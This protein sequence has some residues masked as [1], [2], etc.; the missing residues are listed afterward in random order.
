[1]WR[2]K[3]D[4]RTVYEPNNTLLSATRAE[5]STA[6]SA[7]GSLEL[8]LPFGHALY[9]ELA[10]MPLLGNQW[11]TVERDGSEFWRGR[12]I[13]RN[14]KPLDGVMILLIE[15]E[16]GLL[17]DSVMPPYS[18]TESPRSYLTRLLNAHNAQVDSWKRFYTGRVRV[19]NVAGTGQITRE[20]SSP[21][22]MMQEILTKTCDSSTGGY[23]MLRRVN[24][25]RYLDWVSD[26]A[27]IGSQPIKTAYN[28]LA[29]EDVADGGEFHTAVYAT[30]AQVQDASTGDYYTLTL[31]SLTDRTDQSTAKRGALMINTDLQAKH[32]IIARVVSWQDVT[33]ADNLYTR[34][35]QYV[36]SLSEPRDIEVK[37]VDMSLTG[38]GVAPFEIG[39]RVPL[40]TPTFEGSALVTGVTYDLLDAAGGS[41][42]FGDINSQTLDAG[43]L[44][45]VK[46]TGSA[47]QV[48]S[49][50]QST[51]AQ[52]QA[53]ARLQAQVA[54]GAGITLPLSIAQGGTGSTDAASARAALGVAYSE[55]TVDGWLVR[56]Y[57]DGTKVAT[58][59]LTGSVAATNSYGGAYISALQTTSLPSGVFSAVDYAH[60]SVTSSPGLW[61]AAQTSI[62]TSAANYYVVASSSL[63]QSVTRRLIAVGR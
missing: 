28:L 45:A 8:Q 7:A 37:A 48:A 20:S 52:A 5:L 47:A 26:P 9:S 56:Y 35:R 43:D 29:C 13:Q 22:A 3:L 19:A 32:G 62:S 17:N 54:G 6:L 21:T 33:D 34:A 39:Q 38:S 4:G 51:Q 59:T 27:I 10:A 15:G 2:I 14:A 18:V 46:T 25:K 53:I 63:T 58:R 44:V 12:L 24:G 1:M 16:L 23:L 31:D 61:W 50:T 60:V 57:P 11:W 55:S 42:T 41:V 40:Q 36:R 30:G 49:A